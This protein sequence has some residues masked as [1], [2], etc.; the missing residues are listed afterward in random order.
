MSTENISGGAPAR[1]QQPGPSAKTTEEEEEEERR[2]SCRSQEV[3]RSGEVE[4]ADQVLHYGS[5]Q[6]TGPVYCLFWPEDGLRRRNHRN[7]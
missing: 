4:N 7:I 1:N 6:H 5:R 2:H 3:E